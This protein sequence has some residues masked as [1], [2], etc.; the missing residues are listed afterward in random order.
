MNRIDI[1]GVGFDNVTKNEALARCMDIVSSK[2]GYVAT[3]NP[4]IV[5]RCR[6]DKTAFDVVNGASLIIPDGIG[7]IYASRILSKPV[8][9]RIPGIDLAAALMCE[10]E[11]Q[12]KT[13]FLLGA[14]PGV[15][16][17][18][19]EKLAVTYPNLAIVGTNDGYFTDDSLVIDK[20]N[21]V[22]PDVIFVCLGSPRQEQWAK[23]NLP[24]LNTHLCMCLGGSLDVFSGNVERAPKIYQKLGL[25][26][27][28]R[29]MKEPS[30]IGRMLV[31]PKFILL[32]I[33]ERLCPSC[34]K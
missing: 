32:A 27:F 29:L 28:Y 17:M 7:I 4:E 14:K 26:W 6:R 2:K 25:E 9:E 20:I 11:K 30:R 5:Y 19:A 33:K 18:A 34:S 1:L 24:K 16:D 10:L 8:K 3:P 12:G 21:A 23:D 22:S 13:L 31:L 15:A